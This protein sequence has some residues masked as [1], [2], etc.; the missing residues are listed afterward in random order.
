MT[1][2]RTVN[3]RVFTALS[4]GFVATLATGH[5]TGVSAQEATPLAIEPMG[6]VSMRLRVLT[7]PEARPE[8]NE[9]VESDFLPAI[10][11]LPGYSGYVLA[12]VVDVDTQ[13]VSVVVFK[14]SD[15]VAGFND[16]A[17]TFVASV[18][19]RVDAA[20][21]QQWAGD[22]LMKAGP[23]SEA[24][25]AAT[26][27]ADPAGP[28][29]SGYAAVRIHTS[30][31]GTDPRDFVAE[32]VDGF[33][34]LITVLPGFRGYLWF[35][36]DGGFAAITIYDSEESATASSDAAVAWATEHLA[37]YTDGNP[38]II[39]AGVVYSDLPILA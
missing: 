23:S 39:N 2:S 7:T 15:Q 22:L 14:N 37:A 4:G 13:S 9:L 17:A 21:T 34:P 1:L 30:L 25:A 3:R 5:L 8:V 20:A 35:P 28:L 19:D 6:F 16:A 33:L 27:M 32:A 31:P 26:P 11:G 38:T 10:T 24:G 29:T 36:V 12:D 18:G